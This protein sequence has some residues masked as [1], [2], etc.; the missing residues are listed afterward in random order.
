MARAL[1]GERLRLVLVFLGLFAFAAWLRNPG[2][3]EWDGTSILLASRHFEAAERGD[4]FLYRYALQ[5]LAFQLLRAVHALGGGIEA[6]SLLPGLFGAA[7]VAFVL[8]AMGCAAPRLALLPRIAIVALL[9]ELLFSL[10]YVNATVLA[11]PFAAAAAWLAV[12]GGG[13]PR[14]AA[15]AGACLGVGCLFRMD[16]AIAAPLLVALVARDAPGWPRVRAFAAALA[17]VGLAALA[18]GVL[19][20]LELLAI[21]GSHESRPAAFGWT[22]ADSLR[23][24]AVSMSPFA[25][26][27]S[28]GALG[29]AL[30]EVRRGAREPLV[31]AL[32]A[33]PLAAPVPTLFSPKYLVP[34]FCLLPVALAWALERALAGA[35][36]SARRAAVW[37]LVAVAAFAQ[38][39]SVGTSPSF[40]FARLDTAPVD[41]VETHD[42]ARSTGAYARLY[43]RVRTDLFPEARLARALANHI[44]RWGGS[45]VVVSGRRGWLMGFPFV[46]LP[47]DLERRGFELDVRPGHMLARRGGIRVALVERESA[48]D[49]AV[50]RAIDSLPGP[51]ALLD[52]PDFAGRDVPARNAAVQRFVAG[53][54]ARLRETFAPGR[55]P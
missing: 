8:A 19:R 34:A 12:R 42:G 4:V 27:A 25:W 44:E 39:A 41:V 11:L 35:S 14:A 37:G 23:V 1:T 32:L 29:V 50:R 5:P 16:F 20:P 21:V 55:R 54:P 49:P 2:F 28:L 52:V 9:P 51:V 45:V 10:L 43:A 53:F 6:A 30:A 36:A 7:G 24:L 31:Y 13:G 33:L 17:G 22:A 3:Y 47:L 18:A 26:L 15:L 40:P 48:D 38:L 46:S